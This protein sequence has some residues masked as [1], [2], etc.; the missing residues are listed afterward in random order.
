VKRNQYVH[1]YEAVGVPFDKARTILTERSVPA[2]ESDE[3]V[4]IPAFHEG[5]L[6]LELEVAGFH[7]EKEAHF[8]VSDYV[9]IPGHLPLG[10][11]QLRWIPADASTLVPPIAAELEIEPIDDAR[12]MISLL[13]NYEAPFGR[14]GTLMDRVA[15]HR[16]ADTALKRYFSR[17]VEDLEKAP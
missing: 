5:D 6:S 10:R 7:L 14:L 13:A 17:L 11:V 12:T 8:E 9:D 2:L 3:P 15:M 1:L 4:R 16:I